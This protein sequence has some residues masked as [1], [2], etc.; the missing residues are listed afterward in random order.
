MS[1]SYPLKRWMGLSSTLCALLILVFASPS[2]SKIYKWKDEN[3]KT[4]F[5]DN[6][7]KIPPQYR[8][9]GELKTFK[10]VPAEPSQA[11]KLLVPETKATTHVIKARSRGGHYVVEV[12]INGKIHAD[13]IVDTGATMV[14][15]SESLGQKL[16]VQHNPNFPKIG[17]NTAGGKVETPLFILDSL[18]LGDAEAVNVEAST[19]P[20]LD[21]EDGLLGMTFLEN[22]RVEM[23][24]ETSEL[25][26]KPLAGPNDEVW[27]GKNAKWWQA[28]YSEYA[29][30]LHHL[31]RVKNHVQQDLQKSSKVK[32][33]IAHYEK[34]HSDLDL[35]ADRANL[36][37]EFR[38]Y[39]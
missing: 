19:N 34:L 1:S 37:K 16:G 20:N 2:H 8:K 22:F 17:F 33:L 31:H 7:S 6:P 9:K 32:K 12:V 27:G 11:V 39:P 30:N 18:S 26:L 23:N 3:G 15:L 14:I 21:G 29:K 28:K 10:G 24:R 4:H 35:R 13:L 25:I 36:P 38:I 5:T